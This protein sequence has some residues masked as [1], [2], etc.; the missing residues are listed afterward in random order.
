MEATGRV[1]EKNE[2]VWEPPGVPL[3]ED[4]LEDLMSECVGHWGR[5]VAKL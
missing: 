4:S 1:L 3:W 2:A 5:Y